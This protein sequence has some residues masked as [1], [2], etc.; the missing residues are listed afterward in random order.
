MSKL[1]K[2]PVAIPAGVTLTV[3]PGLVTVKCPKGEFKQDYT[4]I[5]KI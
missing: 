5:V 1:G 3:S 2:L 4:N